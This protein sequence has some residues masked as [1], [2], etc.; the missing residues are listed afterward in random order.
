MLFDAVFVPHR[1][2]LGSVGSGWQ[3]VTEQLAFERGGAER[4][5]STYPLVALRRLGQGIAVALDVGQAPGRLA[6]E[7]KLLGTAFEKDVVETARYVLDVC[8]ANDADLELL[9]DATQTVPAG[10]IRDGKSEILRTVI[11]RAEPRR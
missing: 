3:Q 5:L 10:S 9:A 1:R 7:L 4:F 6:A 8:G 2:V 11:S